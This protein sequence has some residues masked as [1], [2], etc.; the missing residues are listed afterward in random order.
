MTTRIPVSIEGNLVDDPK[1]G[2]SQGNVDYARFTV[3][4]NDRR[5]MEDGS[6][7]TTNTAFHDVAVFHTQARN[8]ADSLRKGDGVVVVGEMRFSRVEKDGRTFDNRDIIADVVGPSL[9]HATAQVSRNRSM[10]GP[11]AGWEQAPKVT[12]PDAYATGPVV[13]PEATGAE[14]A[15]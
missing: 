13:A 9:R 7:D 10:E 14:I 12:S 4:T 11:E 6:W 5:Q 15:R 3:A 1:F 2:T 8:V